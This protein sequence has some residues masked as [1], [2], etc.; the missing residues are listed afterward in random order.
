MRN[1][2]ASVRDRADARLIIEANYDR[3]DP[4]SYTVRTLQM[5]PSTVRDYETKSGRYRSDGTGCGYRRG[6]RRASA[7]AP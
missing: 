3:G 6:W 1:S 5:R 2:F 4:V 7:F